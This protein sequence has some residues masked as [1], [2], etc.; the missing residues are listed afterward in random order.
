MSSLNDCRSR[1]P[2]FER[3]TY[4]NSCSQ[5]ALS[6]SVRAAYDHYLTDWDEKG[7]PRSSQPSR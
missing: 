7:A 4:V 6:D 5:G 3:L 1:F 2:I